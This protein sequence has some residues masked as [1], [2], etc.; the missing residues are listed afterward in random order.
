M[1][2]S[3]RSVLTLAVF[4]SVALALVACN[5]S[6][7]PTAPESLSVASAT[8]S[9]AVPGTSPE[10]GGAFVAKQGQSGST[11]H[12][13]VDVV[14]FDFPN[15]C[16]PEIVRF[17]GTSER[18]IHFSTDAQGNEHFRFVT[19]ENQTGVGLTT[20]DSYRAIGV[21]GGGGRNGIPFFFDCGPGSCTANLIARINVLASDPQNSMRLNCSFHITRNA[22]GEI[23]SVFDTGCGLDRQFC[24]K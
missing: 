17:N 5:Q 22:A 9:E 11:V 23:T 1:A 7:S 13:V 18:T 10:A 8:A 16:V 19:R 15:D 14:D 12:F 21:N 24:K 6:A 20:G 3:S 2:G 4:G